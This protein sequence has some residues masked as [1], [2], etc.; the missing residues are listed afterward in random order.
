MGQIGLLNQLLGFTI[1]IIIII[2]IS[3][4]ISNSS[5]YLKPDSFVQVVY[6]IDQ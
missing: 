6:S 1:N 2:I 5:T 4:S 3:C